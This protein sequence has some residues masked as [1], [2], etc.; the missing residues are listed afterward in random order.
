MATKRDDLVKELFALERQYWQ[1][2]RDRDASTAMR[3]SDDAFIVTGAQ[4]VDTME[5]TA[6]AAMMA[7]QSYAL[8][9]FRIDEDHA[10]VSRLGD[11]V[12][13]LAYQVHEELTVDGQPVAF[14]AAESSTWV[15]RD[16]SWRCAL[17][18][19]SILG[20]PFGRDRVASA[21]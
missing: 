7:T 10:Q 9:S 19:E 1:A 3:L 15:R 13:V 16:G 21:R 18:T 2:L 12:A 17:H 20:D 8:R 11:D 14:D 4:G 6:I 5:R